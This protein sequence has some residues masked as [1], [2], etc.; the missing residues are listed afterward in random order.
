MAKLL[1]PILISEGDK[2]TEKNSG[3]RV[4]VLEASESDIA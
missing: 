3:A 2:L 4:I 1:D